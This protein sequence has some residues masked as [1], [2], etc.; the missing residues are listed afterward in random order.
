LATGFLTVAVWD[1]AVFADA[2]AAGFV[3]AVL[4]VV[5]LLVV[6]RWDVAALAGVFLGAVLSFRESLGSCALAMVAGA[7]R[8]NN[9]SIESNKAELLILRSPIVESGVLTL[10]KFPPMTK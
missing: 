3:A 9:S 4:D 6:T 7:V 2:E 5:P 10:R 8:T 1:D